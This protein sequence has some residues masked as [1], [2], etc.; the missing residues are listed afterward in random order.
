M[1]QP[2][3]T[4]STPSAR[5]EIVD[6]VR[7][8]AV[9]ITA[10]VL[11]QSVAYQPFTIPS[12]SMEPGLLVGDYLVV[13][14]SAYGWS[15]AS[16]PFNPPL[17]SGR[18][19][20]RLPKRGD[21]VV[22]RRPSTP[23]ETWIKRVI[24]LPGDRVEVVGGQVIVNGAALP[25]RALGPG[26]DPDQPGRPVEQV[27]ERQA[28]GRTYITFD[29]GQGLEGDNRPAQIVPQGQL[30]VMGDNR[31]NSLDSRWSP[32][33]GVGLLP[34]T[35]VIGK[36]EVVVASWKPGAALWKP[37]TWFNLRSGRLFRPID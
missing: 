15:R 22:F 33:V 34:V 18:L 19:F 3:E 8:I 37:W 36:A 10:A 21:V 23:Q 17:P 1:T 31:D 12:A 24:G 30:F 27:E 2:P 13:S 32:D 5:A 35:N 11:I 26:L 7:T 14:K 29:G 20:E 4:P 9:G 28:D 16:L 6:T 25:Q